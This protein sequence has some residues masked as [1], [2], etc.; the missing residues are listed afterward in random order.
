MLRIF[1]PGLRRGRTANRIGVFL[2]LALLLV[3]AV[4]VLTG[5]SKLAAG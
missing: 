4:S 1:Q 3:L 2:L 5:V